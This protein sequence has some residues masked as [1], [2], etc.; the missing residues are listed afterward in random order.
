MS[1]PRL[2]RV[3]VAKQVLAN[4]MYFHASFMLPLEALLAKI[5]DCIDWFVAK[6]HWEEPPHGHIRL[7]RTPQQGG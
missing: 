5:V 2:G 3:H 4:S 7:T 1:Y 6:G